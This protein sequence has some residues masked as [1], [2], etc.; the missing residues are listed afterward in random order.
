MYLK[1]VCLGGFKRVTSWIT[2]ERLVNISTI[3]ALIIIWYIVSAS[4]RS[5]YLPSPTDVFKRSYTTYHNT[6]GVDISYSLMRISVGFI[7]GSLL[8]IVLGIA[9]SWSR[10]IEW[11]FDPL[12]EIIRPVPVLALIPLFVLWFGIGEIS[13]ILL[14]AFGAFVR[15][16]VITREAI[17]NVP[18]IYLQAAQTLGATGKV[19]LFRTVILPA[20][21][22]E[23]IGGLRVTAAAAFGYCAAAEFLGAQRG[24]GY[25]I[26]RARRYL[27]TFAVI[28]G[29]IL[30][31]S[32]SWVADRI[33]RYL[34]HR[35]NVWTERETRR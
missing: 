23:V 3:V 19:A 1:R 13:K 27:Y 26:I 32:F 2:I 24:V 30:F 11:W 8:G 7:L 16:V 12:I 4:V 29:I 9:L 34:D 22:P 28:F 20:V 31:S 15:M 17:K 21:T 35:I 6:L 14:I 25:M 33:V 5:L 10:I 18:P